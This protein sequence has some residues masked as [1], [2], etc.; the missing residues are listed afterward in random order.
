MGFARPILTLLVDRAFFQSVLRGRK[1]GVRVR[2]HQDVSPPAGEIKASQ[3]QSVF[4]W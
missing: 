4:L 2:T 3:C 1:Q